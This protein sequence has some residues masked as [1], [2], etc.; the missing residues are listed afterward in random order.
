M[1]YDSVENSFQAVVTQCIPLSKAQL[2]RLSDLAWAVLLAGETSLS[3]IARQLSHATQQDSRIRWIQ[4][5]LQAPFMTQATLYHPWIKHVLHT[6]QATTLHLV[7]DRTDC[8]DHRFD[9][10]AINLNFRKRAFVNN[11]LQCPQIT[12][13]RCHLNTDQ[14]VPRLPVKLKW[15]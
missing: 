14:Q 13:L 5:L 7:L 8:I 4:R 11:E 3:K 15:A 6:H 1:H 12:G 9:L 10:V 2:K